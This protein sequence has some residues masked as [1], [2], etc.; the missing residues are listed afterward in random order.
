MSTPGWLSEYVEKVSDLLVETVVL[1]LIAKAA[2]SPR[3][4][5]VNPHPVLR[6]DLSTLCC[7]RCHDGDGHADVTGESEP[8]TLRRYSVQ[9]AISKPQWQMSAG[10]VLVAVTCY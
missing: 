5:V 1:R 8:M 3:T 10:S 7:H 2:S 9:C 6:A 4:R